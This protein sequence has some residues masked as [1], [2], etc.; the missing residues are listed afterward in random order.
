MHLPAGGGGACGEGGLT[1]CPCAKRA[2]AARSA[3]RAPHSPAAARTAAPSLSRRRSAAHREEGQPGSPPC[4]SARPSGFDRKSLS[5]DLRAQGGPRGGGEG[6]K[7]RAHS[8]KT[9]A[10]AR[11]R[12][13][14]RVRGD[15]GGASLDAKER[16][17]Y[18]RCQACVKGALASKSHRGGRGS[19]RCEGCAIGILC[20]KGARMGA[21]KGA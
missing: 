5:V 20:W 21:R 7:A 11:V 15:D 18:A 14:W 16:K 19:M 13:G 17:A 10:T 4:S 9:L 2:T 6:R 12:H 8:R 1:P 3:D